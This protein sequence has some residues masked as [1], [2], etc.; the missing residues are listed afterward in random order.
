MA[1]LRTKGKVTLL[2]AQD[3]GQRFGPREDSIDADVIFKISTLPNN[4]FGFTLR[5]D[6]HRPTRQGMLDLLR[7]AFNHDWDLEVVYDLDDGKNNG[8]ARRVWIVREPS[9]AVSGGF[10]VVMSPIKP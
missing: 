8:M 3:I 4:H 1:L 9:E 7:D 5:D 6:Q 2:R 10:R